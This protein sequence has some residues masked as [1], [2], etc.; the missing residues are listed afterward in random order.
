MAMK[1]NKK[2]NLDDCSVEVS[3]PLSS[4]SVSYSGSIERFETVLMN[5]NTMYEEK[6]D[7]APACFVCL[8]GPDELMGMYWIISDTKTMTV[9]RSRRCDIAIQDLSIS[10]EHLFISKDVAKK[11][12]IK[13]KQSTN[14]TFVNGEQITVHQ[15]VH[16]ED[17]DQIKLGNIVF[18]FLN[19]GNPEIFS[20]LENF[21]KAFHDALTGV[22]NKLLLERRA[23]ELFPKSRKYKTPLSVIIFDIDHFK[24]V[25]DTYGH[26]AGDLVLKEVVNVAKL[27]F[28]SGDTFARCG[29]EEFCVI[30]QSE[31]GR[32]K[33][34]IEV[35]RK[36]L[37]DSVFEHKDRK[38]KVTIS[39]GVTCRQDKDKHWNE[40]YERADQFLY[41]AKMAGRNRTVT[42]I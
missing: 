26:L 32:A 12:F 5:A 8:K 33:E 36:K 40:L 30:M 11:V 25:N 2:T 35:A 41:K 9:G 42:S 19:T 20:V 38:I 27:C 4:T 16:L 6:K 15:N 13:D 18:K 28:R 21:E 31:L 7:V 23:K 39:A 14:G 22:G 24:K 37:E 29:G 1:L 34:A 10:K 3:D 17:N